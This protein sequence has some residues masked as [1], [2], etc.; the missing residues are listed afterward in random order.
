M[1]A[2]PAGKVENHVTS[3]DPRPLSSIYTL[4]YYIY[5][6]VYSISFFHQLHEVFI[7]FHLQFF[8]TRYL[9]SYIALT[10]VLPF[11]FYGAV[12]A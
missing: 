11:D 5:T 10:A 8:V 9:A 4:L 7:L 12:C 2:V 3:L 6:I 1:C